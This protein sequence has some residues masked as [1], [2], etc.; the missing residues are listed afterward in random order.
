MYRPGAAVL[1]QS[2]GDHPCATT[3]GIER[4]RAG[5]TVTTVAHPTVRSADRVVFLDGGRYARFW[6]LSL[7]PA[8][9]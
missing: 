5:G 8:N 2:P 4:L 9:D 6:N 7:E 1:R 3:P